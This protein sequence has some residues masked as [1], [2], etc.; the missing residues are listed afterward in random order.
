MFR[1]SV[2]TK[3]IAPSCNVLC[4]ARGGNVKQ[5]EEHGCFLDA[6]YQQIPVM[7]FEMATRRRVLDVT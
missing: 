3:L 5:G 2:S 7:C 4:E 6:V 1:D